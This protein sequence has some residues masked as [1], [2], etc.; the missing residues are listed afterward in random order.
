M[1][2]I[3]FAVSLADAIPA[4]NPR[5]PIRSSLLAQIQLRSRPGFAVAT[6]EVGRAAV[7]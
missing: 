3:S 6:A 7:R 1:G 2:S 5:P 4:E